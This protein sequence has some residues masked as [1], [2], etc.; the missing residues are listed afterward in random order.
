MFGELDDKQTDQVLRS[1]NI[2]RLGC[3]ASGWPYVVPITYVYDGGTVYAHSAEGLKLRAMRENP[4]VCLEIEQL[5][6]MANWR[7]VLVRG[8]FEELFS[9]EEERALTLLT[10]RLDRMETSATA[11]LVQHEDIVHREGLRRP[12]LFCIRVEDRTGRFELI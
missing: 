5:R 9:D 4:R 3:I 11:R 2:G 10:T 12:I 7:T 1:E 6:S 8:R